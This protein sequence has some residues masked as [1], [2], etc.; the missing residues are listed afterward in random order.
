VVILV[1]FWVVIASVVVVTVG[2]EDVVV[3]VLDVSGRAATEAGKA[4]HLFVHDLRISANITVDDTN[5]R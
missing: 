4:G 2:T 5:W 1:R 3:L